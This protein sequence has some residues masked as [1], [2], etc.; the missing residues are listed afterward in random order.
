LLAALLVTGVIV[1]DPVSIA[2]TSAYVISARAVLYFLFLLFFA[3]LESG[4]RKGVVA[5][6][7]FFLASVIFYM[8]YEQQGSSLNLFALRYTDMM[9]DEFQMPASWLQAVPAVSVLIFAPVFAWLWVWL[10][11]RNLNPPTPVKLSMGLLF[12]ALSYILMSAAAWVVVGGERAL[13]TWLIV[14]YVLQTFGEICLYPVGLSAVKKLAP[15]RYSA[16]LMGVWFMSLALGNLM[17]GLMAGEMDA[18]R[19]AVEPELL[20]NIFTKIAI[21]VAV[22]AVFILVLN[23]Y[24]FKQLGKT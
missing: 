18:D 15:E 10:S 24:L 16:Q 3:K 11:R 17:A 5:I 23:R 9:I 14:T 6:S 2:G 12:V 22:A 20:V 13:P 7:I 4:E 8:G 1:A 21:I 19:I